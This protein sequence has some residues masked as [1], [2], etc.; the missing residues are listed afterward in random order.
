M[1]DTNLVIEAAKRLDPSAWAAEKVTIAHQPL[2]QDFADR[3]AK[4]LQAVR[5]VLETLKEP[6]DG[7]LEAGF[8]AIPKPR[9]YD[10]SRLKK[11]LIGMLNFVLGQVEGK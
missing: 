4:S 9:P 8:Y 2:A 11:S 3:R 5:L 6:T 10:T 1:T 7:M